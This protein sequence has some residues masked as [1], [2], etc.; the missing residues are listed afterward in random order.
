MKHLTTTKKI[1]IAILLGFSCKDFLTL[2]AR[3]TFYL[4]WRLS[5]DNSML[6]CHR[7]L[8]AY[9]YPTAHMTLL[10]L[11][12]KWWREISSAEE[13]QV[14]RTKNLPKIDIYSTEPGLIFINIKSA[15]SNTHQQVT[16]RLPTPIHTALDRQY[17]IFNLRE[18]RYSDV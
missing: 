6:L 15:W 9:V 11:D 17:S 2:K 16:R 7:D 1:R 4:A 8:N 10:P 5:H 18:S 3:D 14:Q 13:Q 12:H